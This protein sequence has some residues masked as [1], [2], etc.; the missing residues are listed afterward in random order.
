MADRRFI[1][2]DNIDD[3]LKLL[4]IVVNILGENNIKYY[5]DFGTLIGAI[6]DK[7]LIPWDDDMDIS[8]VDEK[9]F[10]K[11]PKVLKEIE[12]RYGYRTYLYTFEESIQR[13]KK[14]KENFTIPNIDFTK[15]SNYQIA[16]IRSNKFWIFG[17]GNTCIDIFFQYKYKNS[18][19]WLIFGKVY[20][21]KK[22]LLDNGFKQIDFYG[23]SCTIPIEY[24]AYLT[25]IYGD[26]KTP[27]ED[28][29]EDDGFAQRKE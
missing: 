14:K 15:K 22:S 29:V 8:L 27:K 2:Q 5:L 3:A 6:R 21:V 10:I 4:K 18:L 24:D 19:Y 28:W 13:L 16:K 20:S 23:I 11:I 26:W 1:H 12:K 7:A 9:D 17:R 25:S